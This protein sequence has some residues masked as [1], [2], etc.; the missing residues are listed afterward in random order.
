[1]VHAGLFALLAATDPAA[2]RRRPGHPGHGA[3]L[4]ALAGYAAVSELA[5][6][7]LLSTRSGDVGDLVA[8]LV[9]VAAG[10]WLAGRAVRDRPTGP[11][12]QL[13]LRT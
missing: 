13:P 11:R 8:D 12:P 7:R 6:A 10:W 3:L 9:G 4:A 5:Q 2:L 1:V